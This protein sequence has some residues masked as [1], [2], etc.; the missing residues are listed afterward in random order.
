[1]EEGFFQIKRIEGWNLPLLTG[2]NFA[3][4]DSG[5]FKIFWEQKILK[6]QE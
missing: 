1:M 5:I 6:E 4:L 2:P 3:A